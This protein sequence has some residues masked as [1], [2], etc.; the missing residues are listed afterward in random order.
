MLLFSCCGTVTDPE[1]VRKTNPM[2]DYYIIGE[3]KLGMC[4]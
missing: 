1:D 3:L 4:T 2:K